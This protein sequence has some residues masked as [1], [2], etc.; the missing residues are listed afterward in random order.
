MIE[1]Y[2]VE[3]TSQAQEQ[4]HLITHYITYELKAPD[5]AFQLLDTLENAFLSLANF[6][7]RIPLMD[8]EPWHTNGIRHFPVKN[9]LIY[10]WIDEENKK[11]Q[12]TAIIYKKRNQ[13]QQLSKM[14]ME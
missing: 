11:V 8:I 4:L 10:F 3:V 6:P 5:A 7:Q 14:D 1:T 2:I 12:I 13:L 9:F